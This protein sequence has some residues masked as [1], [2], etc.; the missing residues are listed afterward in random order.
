MGNTIQHDKNKLLYFI[1]I[2]DKNSSD[3]N[4]II[5]KWNI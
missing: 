2:P 4:P 5:K 1:I 3:V